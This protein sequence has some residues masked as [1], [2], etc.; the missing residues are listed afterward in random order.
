MRPLRL[1][2]LD[3]RLKTV[4][5]L[6]PACDVGADIG[7]DHG[8][9]SCNLL[10]QGKTK[11]MLVTDISIPSLEKAKQLLC[12]HGLDD[13][14]DFCQGDGLNA[15]ERPAGGIAICGMGGEVIRHILLAGKERLHGAS[16]VISPQTDI[17][18]VRETVSEIGYHI[19]GEEAVLSSGRYYVIMKAE[20]GQVYYSEKELFLGPVLMKNQHESTHGYYSWR[21]DVECCV[22][23]LDPKYLEWLREVM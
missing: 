23:N 21:Y 12:I 1:P 3:E 20:P 11:H 2:Q 18:L 8:R 19:N 9:L 14:A 22:K 13:R 6:F 17:P 16:V 4:F 15:L 7:A 5:E 10:A